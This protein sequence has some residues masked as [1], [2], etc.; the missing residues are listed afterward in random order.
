MNALIKLLGLVCV[1]FYFTGCLGGGGGSSAT[2]GADGLV[3]DPTLDVTVTKKTGRDFSCLLVNL[4]DRGQVWC[5]SEGAP[6]VRLGISSGTYALYAE[7]DSVTGFTR[8]ET[9]DD[10]V[11]VSATV[12]DRPYNGGAGNATYC[13]GDASLGPNYSGYN[14]VYGGPIYTHATHGTPDLWYATEPFTGGDVSMGLFTNE[15]GMWLVMQDSN[16]AV[17][18]TTETCSLN[19]VTLDLTCNT[20]SVNVQ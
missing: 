16:A 12:T 4:S 11:C 9:W 7:V 17:T 1:V 8:F 2:G 19:L 10:T 14:L 15:G 20:F 18:S 3:P 6:D 5:R 13:F